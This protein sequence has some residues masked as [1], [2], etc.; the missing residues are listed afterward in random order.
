MV[1]WI[2]KWQPTMKYFY[3]KNQ[4]NIKLH[5]D[6]FCYISKSYLPFYKIINRATTPLNDT[7]FG[8]WVDPDL[9][10]YLDDYVGCDVG[11]G[12]GFCYN[13]DAEC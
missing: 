9:G 5:T 8:Q 2:K 1:N 3:F 13:G 6:Y 12:L 4:K 11:L 7:Y 10:F